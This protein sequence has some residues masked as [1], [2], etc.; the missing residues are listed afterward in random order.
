MGKTPARRWPRAQLSWDP[1]VHST[2]L[3]PTLRDWTGKGSISGQG[4]KQ[5]H[6]LPLTPAQLCQ[7]SRGPE[8]LGVSE[9][10]VMN[11]LGSR[12]RSATYQ[13]CHLG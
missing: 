2:F 3:C 9:Q 1:L 5:G 6:F 7:P 8:G 10:R 12:A 11:C 13:H 4:L